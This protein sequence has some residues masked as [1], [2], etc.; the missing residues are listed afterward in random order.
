[1]THQLHED[2]V[3][4]QIQ[5]KR[6]GAECKKMLISEHREYEDGISAELK[7]NPA[8]FWKFFSSKRQQEI[9]SLHLWDF[10]VPKLIK[11][12]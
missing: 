5:F 4:L 12:F 9:F 1:M 6:L 10:K 7:R 8:A 3:E 11:I 2:P